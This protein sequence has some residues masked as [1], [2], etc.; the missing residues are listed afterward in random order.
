MH[1][2]EIYYPGHIPNVD[3][4]PKVNAR[5]NSALYALQSFIDEMALSLSFY[6]ETKNN[7]HPDFNMSFEKKRRSREE[8]TLIYKE[9]YGE[10]VFNANQSDFLEK[11]DRQ[12][13]KDTWQKGILPESYSRKIPF[14]HAHSF[15]FSLDKYLRL[16]QTL[17]EI[18]SINVYAGEAA[19]DLRKQ[20]QHPGKRA[21]EQNKG[22]AAVQSLPEEKGFLSSSDFRTLVLSCINGDRLGYTL[23]S[24]EYKEFEISRHSLE[25]AAANF[26]ELINSL[27]W[28]GPKRL[29]PA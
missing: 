23:D 17:S 8:L 5:I 20:M 29:E 2:I 24:G 1:V 10:D 28:T 15:L 14:I 25:I 4:D 7:Y 21:Q 9:A 6:E 3:K 11:I 12:I 16:L 18:P 19:A 27:T 13:K 26:Q 22:P